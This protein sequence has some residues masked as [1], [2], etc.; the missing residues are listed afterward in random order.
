MELKCLRT[1]LWMML[2]T[3]K[4]VIV[5]LGHYYNRHL[6]N[7]RMFG[8]RP[9]GIQEILPTKVPY[10]GGASVQLLRMVGLNIKQAVR[11]KV[12]RIWSMLYG[13]RVVNTES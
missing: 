11:L 10:F 1:E 12:T 6:G 4:M 8:V 7:L 5:R 3:R 2:K 9:T 13:G